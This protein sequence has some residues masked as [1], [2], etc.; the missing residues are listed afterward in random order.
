M[1]RAGPVFRNLSGRRIEQR[2]RPVRER[3]ACSGCPRRCE[4]PEAVRHRL[5]HPVRV[6]AG[7]G[8]QD[9]GRGVRDQ[10]R[11]VVG[12][13]RSVAADE[14]EQV[15]HLLQIGR[16]VRV[17]TQEVRVVELDIDDVLDVAAGRRKLTAGR[18]E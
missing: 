8:R 16:H 9:A 14:V 5:S 18:G 4:I 13:Q 10:R 6:D 7:Q 15:R 12:Q 17:V 3:D 1:P 11:V 2:R